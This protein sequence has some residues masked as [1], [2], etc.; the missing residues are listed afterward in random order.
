MA[1][2]PGNDQKHEGE[3]ILKYCITA[4]SPSPPE[5]TQYVDSFLNIVDPSWPPT[6]E[7]IKKQEDAT[8]FQ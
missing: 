1:P 3:T 7:T 2:T 6:P 4:K 8:I 5:T